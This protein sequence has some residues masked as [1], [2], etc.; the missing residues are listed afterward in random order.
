[1]RSRCFVLFAAV[2]AMTAC[3]TSTSGPAGP[4]QPSSPAS[5]PSLAP[6][7]SGRHIYG[8]VADGDNGSPIAGAMVTAQLSS[9]PPAETD[10]N[11]YYDLVATV[12]S[13]AYPANYLTIAKPGYDRTLAWASGN[14]DERHDFRLYR[15]L[16][17]T[18]GS[19][20]ELALNEYSSFCG[21]DDEFKCRVVYIA[22]PAG[23]TLVMETSASDSTGPYWLLIGDP[24]YPFHGVTRLETP[25]TASATVAVQVLHDW[26]AP[27]GVVT[28]RT[29]LSN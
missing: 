25:V 1:M 20:V 4:S 26:T 9:F 6:A 5:V 22:V 13:G 21:Y 15:P 28:L 16:Q 17:A 12:G 18:A 8:V 10:D 29:T 24:Q 27:A 14:R 7:T 23:G 19:T 3:G 11:G 2:V